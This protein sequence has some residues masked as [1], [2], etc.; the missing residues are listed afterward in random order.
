MARPKDHFPTSPTPPNR[1]PAARQPT[2]PLEQPQDKQCG[3]RALMTNYI[4][5]NDGTFAGSIGDGKNQ[6]P[7][8]A[9]TIDINVMRYVLNQKVDKDAKININDLYAAYQAEQAL[10]TE[11][12]TVMRD[13][14]NLAQPDT[15][16]D[17]TKCRT[18]GSQISPTLPWF[19]ECKKC[20]DRPD[21][22]EY[23]NG[24]GCEECDDIDF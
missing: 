6:T 2:P 8:E 11:R 15:E 23:C 4:Q 22:C 10:R 7:T 16:Q 12:E 13:L 14:L 17:P 1:L 18:C 21:V 3:E 19:G 9:P 5:N 20:Y 24:N